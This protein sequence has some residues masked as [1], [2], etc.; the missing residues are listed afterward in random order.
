[1]A[2][3]LSML[4]GNT[5]GTLSM[6]DVSQIHAKQEK[7]EQGLLSIDW[8]LRTAIE[9]NTASAPSGMCRSL[10]RCCVSTG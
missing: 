1:M 6:Y 5:G 4:S 8:G 7:R 3:I 2:L 10:K 9:L